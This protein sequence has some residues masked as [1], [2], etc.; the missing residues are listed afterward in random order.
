MLKPIPLKI[1]SQKITLKVCT[2]VDEW[3]DPTF[4]T[5]DLTRVHVQPTH[6]TRMTRDNTEVA[7]NSLL[8][9]DAR[10]STPRL[11]FEALQNTS[12]EQGGPMHVSFNGREYAV[13]TI[14][15][16]PDDTGR[17]HHYE[18]GLV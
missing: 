8:F 7:L 2:G 6:D 18:V 11:D 1:L 12:L 14:D 16:V 15:A 3:Q 5:Y 9:V 10:L 13:M 4:I 17:L